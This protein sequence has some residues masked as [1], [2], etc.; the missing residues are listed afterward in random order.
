MVLE[1]VESK[2]DPGAQIMLKWVGWLFCDVGAIQT[3]TRAKWKKLRLQIC[4]SVQFCWKFCFW[5]CA[6]KISEV[7]D[8]AYNLSI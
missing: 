2:S 1:L 3:A 4:S 6:T 8:P 7:I 5:N